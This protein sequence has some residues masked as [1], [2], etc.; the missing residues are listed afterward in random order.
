MISAAV[1]GVAPIGFGLFRAWQSGSDYRMFWMAVAATLFAGGTLLAA[2]GR[3]RSQHAV[4]V[5]AIAIFVGSTLL[6][7]AAAYVFGA[8]AWFGV[9]AVAAVFGALLSA[10]SMLVAVRPAAKHGA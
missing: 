2:I 7:G 3:R 4:R 9:W 1:L 10:A 6:A 8:T 5:Q